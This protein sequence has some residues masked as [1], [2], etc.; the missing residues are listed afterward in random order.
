MSLWRF[1]FLPFAGRLPA[2]GGTPCPVESGLS[3]P[4]HPC[5]RS[6]ATE[7]PLFPDKNH[8]YSMRPQNVQVMMSVRFFASCF[9]V[10]G[11]DM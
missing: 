10:G 5:G 2:D 11:S 3:S 4:E 1:P 8:A 6:A 7:S 9:W